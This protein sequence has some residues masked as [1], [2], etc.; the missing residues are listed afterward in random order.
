MAAKSIDDKP[1]SPNAYIDALVGDGW[2]WSGTIT[3]LFDNDTSDWTAAEKDAYRGALQSWA[4][5]ANIT[6]QE[7]FV[8]SQANLVAHSV[9][10]F[11]LPDALADHATPMDA[12]KTHV[13]EGRFNY[14]RYSIQ[15][16]ETPEYNEAGL[17]KGGFGY[18]T[19]VHELGHALGLQH[20]H[21]TEDGSGLFPGVT[22]D[23]SGDLGDNNLNQVIYTVMSYNE[24]DQVS[25]DSSYG[26]AAGPMAYDIAAIQYLYG[27]KA[28][29]TG[30]DTYWLPDGNGAGT[31]WSCIWD[32]AGTDTI[33]YGG[34]GFATID[35]RAATLDNS[36]T[37]GGMIS[38]ITD[39]TTGKGIHGG[40]TIANG[41]M[42]EN[43]SGGAN[44]DVIRGNNGANILKGN[45]GND[46]LEGFDGNDVL[47]QGLGGGAMYG[48]N[49]NDILIAGNGAD[50]LDGGNGSDTA[51]YSR[52]SNYIN[53]DTTIGKVDGGWATGDT[54]VSI[55]KIIGTDFDDHIVMGDG[56]NTIDGGAGADMLNGGLG[57]DT[58]MGGAG[59]DTL[60]GGLGADSIGG[61]SGFDVATFQSAVTINLQTGARSGEAVGDTY[62]SIEQF[63]GSAQS[64]TMV[65]SNLQGA[66]FA[67]GDGVD[68]LYGG[69]QGDWLQG[70]RGADYINGGAG[71]DT[72][73]Y[74]DAAYGVTA[75]M[76]FDG[77]TTLGQTEGKITAGEWG[78]DTLVS[79]ENVEGSAFGDYLIG[80]ERA[81]TFWGLGGDD[82]IVGDREGG[83]QSSADTM[84]GG[85][86]SDS[87]LIGANDSA[88]GGQG[89]DT[90]SFVGGPIY[91]NFNA[92]AFK[93]GGQSIWIAEFE[94]YMGTG[95]GDVVVGAAHGETISL[96][97]GNDHLYGEGGDDFLTIGAGA[98]V[99]S[100]GAGYDTMV[101]HKAMVA[102]WQAGVLDTDISSDSWYSWEAIQGSSGNDVIRTNSW[103]FSVE[104]R[105]GAGD[106]LLAAGVTG[107]VS[108]ILNGEAGDDILDGGAGDD[109]L[110]G[111]SGADTFVIGAGG[112]ID[113]ITD[114]NAAEGDKIDFTGI[115]GVYG[116]ADLTV[117]EYRGN[118][119]IALARGEGV[120]FRNISSET[121][122]DVMFLF[123]Q[124]PGNQAPVDI[125]L[126]NWTI[127]ENAAIDTVVG[128]LAAIDPDLDETFTY[129]LLDDAGGT[130]A[131]A[132]DAIVVA[133]ALDFETAAA[134]V[135]TVRATDSAGNI[136]DKNFAI[137]VVDTD[138]A[139]TAAPDGGDDTIVGS[140]G[141]EVMTGGAGSDI[142]VF[143]AAQ[144]Q[145]GDVDT[146][147]D[148]VVGEDHLAFDGLMVVEQTEYDVD[149][150]LVLDTALTLDDGATVQLLGV[151]NADLWQLLA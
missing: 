84:Y 130:F 27:A 138:D 13:V 38:R 59:D 24:F 123:A 46:L 58:L 42:I 28:A 56:A 17:V 26:Y 30:S 131:I 114:F 57:A 34:N 78:T 41:V 127:E 55:E 101:F 98:D 2:H 62:V 47:D 121:L 112:G 126:L 23:K 66:R 145:A 100:G 107:V 43:A 136:V 134:H 99:M 129:E 37:G 104:L 115:A 48:G 106:D 53:I 82:I 103:G 111:G 31:Y 81:N 142:F 70:G 32:T 25:G 33:A 141:S 116:L 88:Y 52:S 92:N 45:N 63:N 54:L 14:Q 12:R 110:T 150:D 91:L 5:V 35:L 97:S 76:Y 135:V 140:L 51:D 109:G 16:T 90:A 9:S 73:S 132:G 151:N 72:V 125:A 69:S 146:V 39:A 22:E 67:G 44:D 122:T 18:E 124:D 61:G 144:S 119:T 143:Q 68:Y 108:D 64:D 120:V 133:G 60:H 10:D 95:G 137:D 87:I 149:G 94:A 118:T 83:P 50:I 11:T 117:T 85:A 79:I 96:G 102:D 80:D 148:F 6:F 4:N 86:G 3:Y 65:A 75:E 105:G 113:L 36:P 40:F 128:T 7:V 139:P 20:P 147:A 29:N 89:Y 93:V 1:D 49:D 74:A 21:T 19:F 77:E 15:T 71:S 8:E